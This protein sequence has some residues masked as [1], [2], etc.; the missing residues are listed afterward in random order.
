VPEREEMLLPTD[1]DIGA[2]VKRARIEA[3]YKSEDAFAKALGTS[4]PTISRLESGARRIGAA[5]LVRI[6]E[7]L[8]RQPEHFLDDEASLVFFRDSGEGLAPPTDD[9]FRWLEDFAQRLEA[10]RTYTPKLRMAASVSI[11]MPTPATWEAAQAAAAEVRRQLD[12]G[13]APAPDMFSIAERLG[14]LVVV[15]DFPSAEFLAMYAPRPIGMTLLNSANNNRASRQRFTLAHEI[16]HHLF[17][18]AHRRV[19]VDFDLF[20]QRR[21][22]L[23]NVFAAHFLAPRTGVEAELKRRFGTSRAESAEAA[24]GIA[25]FFGMS[26]ESACYH[27]T[28]LELASPQATAKWRQ[29]RRHALAAKLG[30][31]QEQRQTEAVPLGQRWPPEFIQRLRFALD[32]RLIDSRQLRRHLREDPAAAEDVL[33]ATN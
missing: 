14:C 10:L 12:L 30:V 31:L 17:D 25:F 7:L 8:K 23:A 20:A 3:G 11:E 19:F 29:L 24:Y 21:D 27:L 1:R 18:R 9:A 5:E 32:A 6:A 28:N 15:R 22:Q 16:F 2:R 33:A 4:Q 13:R 26:F